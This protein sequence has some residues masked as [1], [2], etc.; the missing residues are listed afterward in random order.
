MM[1]IGRNPVEISSQKL[2][3]VEA[4]SGDGMSEVLVACS[5]MMEWATTQVLVLDDGVC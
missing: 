3:V 1:V 2:M 5:S 4:C